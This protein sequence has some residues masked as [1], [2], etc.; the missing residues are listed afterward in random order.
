MS[1]ALFPPSV[2]QSVEDAARPAGHVAETSLTLA[3]GYADLLAEATDLPAVLRPMARE[4]VEHIAE[5]VRRLRP[6]EHDAAQP[7]A[8]GPESWEYRTEHFA[9]QS[10]QA[11]G[12]VHNLEGQSWELLGIDF[13]QGMWSFGRPRIPS[14]GR[15]GR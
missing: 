13:R 12:R 15:G 10:P 11:L 9:R 5:V 14:A 3:L 7:A 1:T 2:T 6:A 8:C 4:V